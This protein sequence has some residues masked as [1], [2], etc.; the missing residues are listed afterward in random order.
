MFRG[1]FLLLSLASLVFADPSLP[2]VD[3]RSPPHSITTPLA[4]ERAEAEARLRSRVPGARVDYDL[5]RGGASY[6]RALGGTLSGPG[7]RGRGI[8]LQSVDA[9]P[10]DEP[11]KP[12]KAFLDEHPGLFGHGSDLL[13]GR[14]PVRASLLSDGL[15]QSVAWD[16]RVD[17]I[18]VLEA[19]LI[20]HL[21]RGE[22][23][24]SI[25]SSFV[26]DAEGLAQARLYW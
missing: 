12:V 26:P 5:L 4:G 21:T 6:V 17:G 20:G 22:E 15:G 7:G 24:L 10:S 3:R 25:A 9:L 1:G 14:A 18:P 23:L 11:Y 16:Q 2:T 8:S 19:I 13:A